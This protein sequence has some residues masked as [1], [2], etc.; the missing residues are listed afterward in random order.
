MTKEDAESD[1]LPLLAAVSSAIITSSM[2]LSL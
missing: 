1:Q 2:A